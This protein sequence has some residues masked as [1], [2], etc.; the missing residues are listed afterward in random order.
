MNFG[1][2]RSPCVPVPPPRQRILVVTE[3]RDRLQ[4]VCIIRLQ[5]DEAAGDRSLA[6][7]REDGAEPSGADHV[8]KTVAAVVQSMLQRAGVEARRVVGIETVG[9]DGEVAPIA[10]ESR[11]PVAGAG[12]L[13]LICGGL[14]PINVAIEIEQAIVGPGIG[15]ARG[16]EFVA[17]A[18]RVD[19][20]GRRRRS[21]WKRLA[22]GIGR[23][24]SRYNR[25]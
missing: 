3:G 7:G 11:R 2:M 14:V 9:V 20:R 12:D 4:G 5:L 13:G 25:A 15:P 18:G 24:R 16:R 1:D 6:G 10:D 19:R 23:N 17:R 8:V 21:G 22:S